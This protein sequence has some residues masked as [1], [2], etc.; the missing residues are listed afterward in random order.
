MEDSPVVMY[1]CE[2]WT[3]RRQNAKNWCLWIVVL[4]KTPES[5]LDRKEIK[6]VSLKGDQPWIFT[7]KTDAKAEAPVFW[8][9]D[10]HRWLIGKVP[11]AG[12]DWGHKENRV[13]EDEMAGRHHRCNGRELQQTPGGSEGQGGLTCCSPWGRKESD[14]A[15]QL[16]N[17][18]DSTVAKHLCIHYIS[19]ERWMGWRLP[20]QLNRWLSWSTEVQR[21]AQWHKAVSNRSEV[22]R[23]LLQSGPYPPARY[24]RG[25]PGHTAWGTPLQLAAALPGVASTTGLCFPACCP[26]ATAHRSA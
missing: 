15:G 12:K 14:T 2:S 3:I 23:L 13:S 4:E 25:L 8:S 16:N 18:E 5:P 22:L 17:V 1:R 26:W 24:L 10:A 9:S 20:S 6:P 19:S 21:D 11:D 7:G